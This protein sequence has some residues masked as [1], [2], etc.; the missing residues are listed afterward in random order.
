MDALPLVALIAASAAVAGAAR[1]SPVPAPLLLVAVGLIGAYVPGV[2][3]YTL[4]P[5]IVLPLVLPPLLH[6][7][8]LESSYL[9]LR[10][11]L[12]PVALLSVGYTLFATVA[13]GYLAYLLVPD[14]PLTAALVLG[15]VIAPP[16][17]VAATAIARRLRLPSRITTILQGESLVNDA[18]AITA[19][20]VALAA[21]VG[22]GATWGGGVKEFAL[23]SIGGVGVGLVLMLPIHWLRRHL[24]EA[25]LQNTLSLLIP[26]VAYAAAEQVGASGVLAV[27]VVALYLGHRSW[28]VDFATRLQEE[29]VWKMVS[30][31]LESAVFALIGLQMPVVLKGLGEYGVGEA[32]WYAIGVFVLVVAA[33]FVWVFPATFLPRALSEKIRRREPE[34]DWTAPVIVGWAG[35]R[36]VVSLAIAFSIPLTMADGSAFP[37]RN[38]VLF[39]TFTTV[40]GTLVVQGLTLPPLI[41]LLKLPG[42]DTQ[43]ETL[44]E[45]QAQSEASRAAEARLDELLAD[46][47]STLPPPLAD[48]LRTVLERRRNAVWE[49]LGAVNEVT[50]ESADAT[51]R[52]LSREMIEAERKVF[53][54]LRDDRRIDDEMMR[55][56]LRR[57]DLEE[58]AA[59][60]DP[61]T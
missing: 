33:R 6:T 23:A 16:D 40:I 28:Q 1:R 27:V 59:Y 34:T 47:R 31:L 10:A 4:D 32:V 42:R 50:G 24:R 12:R 52:R 19:Y 54:S 15:A 22:A 25:L 17:A 58:A 20:K 26:F 3:A 43:A 60:R 46:P 57:L 11:N 5:H 55:T 44:A 18:T 35:M 2:P 9:D 29:A 8:A 30:F 41:R 48:R 36:G 39:L 51:Y 7:A 49:R 37:A 14:L 21:A 38:L 53:V 45:A 56:L 61:G 13:V